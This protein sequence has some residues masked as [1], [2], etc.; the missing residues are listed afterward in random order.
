MIK[1]AKEWVKFQS[2]EATKSMKGS[3]TPEDL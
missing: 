2:N 3:K 1:D